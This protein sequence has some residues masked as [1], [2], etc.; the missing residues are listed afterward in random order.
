[1]ILPVVLVISAIVSYLLGG[2]NGAILM[3]KLV[4]HQDIREFGSKNPGFTNFKRTYGNGLP[5]ICVMVID[6]S[7]TVVPVLVTALVCYYNFD[8]WQLGAQFSGTFCMI[9]HC[10]PIWYKFKGGKAFITGFA[11]TWFVDWRMALIAMGI[12]FLLLFTIRYM[13]VASCT[14]AFSAA[15]SLWILW[16][17]NIWVAILCTFSSLLIICRH[18]PNFVKL[19]NHTETKFSLKSKK[20]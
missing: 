5:T 7:K 14:A 3:S 17:D 11:T 8:M 1:M 9:G 6:I 10:F 4:Y 18:Y 19:K 20:E 15:V 12:F 2:I 16:P 13:S